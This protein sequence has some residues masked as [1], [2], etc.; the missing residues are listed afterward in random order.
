MGLHDRLV[1]KTLNRAHIA[2]GGGFDTICT[3]VYQNRCD[4]STTCR[5]CRLELSNWSSLITNGTVSCFMV[6]F[7]YFDS[8]PMYITVF[9]KGEGY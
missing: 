7:V 3:S 8:N 9:V 5:M 2:G 6:I 1:K 4:R